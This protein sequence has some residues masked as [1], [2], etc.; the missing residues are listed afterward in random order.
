MVI[1]QFTAPVGPTVTIPELP[2]EVFE[3]FFT[4]DLQEMIVEESNRYAR[5]VMG[6]ERYAQRTQITVDELKLF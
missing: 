2:L 5:Q 3:L 1:K 6:E 4:R